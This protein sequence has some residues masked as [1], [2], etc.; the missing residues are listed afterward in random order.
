LYSNYGITV[1]SKIKIER[2]W[3]LLIDACDTEEEKRL[4]DIYVSVYPYMDKEKFI[5]FSEFKE[6]HLKSNYSEKSYEEIEAEMNKVIEVY[7]RQ[8]K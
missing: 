6:K 1:E 3:K 7:E 8:V 4:W 2:L 5:D